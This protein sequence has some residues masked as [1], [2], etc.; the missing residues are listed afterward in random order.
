MA[1]KKFQV[2]TKNKGIDIH[3]IDIGKPTQNAYIESF[4]GMLRDE[5]LN[6]NLFK[7]QNE[8]SRALEIYQK[9]YKNERLHSSLNYLSR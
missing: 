8:L 3:F 5:C 4:N 6:L 7:N 2:W 9:D 1:K